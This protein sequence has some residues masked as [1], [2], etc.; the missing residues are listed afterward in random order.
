MKRMPLAV[1]RNGQGIKHPTPGTPLMLGWGKSSE[2]QTGPRAEAGQ[3]V[4][5]PLVLESK[6]QKRQKRT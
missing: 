4:S 5:W 1:V 2:A 6:Q 3:V